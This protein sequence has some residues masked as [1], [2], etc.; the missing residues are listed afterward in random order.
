MRILASVLITGA[1]LLALQAI[2]Q[3]TKEESK[4]EQKMEEVAASTYEHLAT[5][6]IEIERTEDELMKSIL[7]GYH[8]AAKGHLRAAAE[9]KDG[10][11][12]HLE[13]AATEIANIAN[14]GNKRIQA[15]RQRLAK[16]GHTHNTD[17][18]TKE[19]YMF[20]D[21]KEKKEL[22]ALARKVSQL[23]NAAS[24]ND[25]L[26]ALKEFDSLFSRVIASE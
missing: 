7:L 4:S 15:I 20:V 22:V 12:A 10:K 2:G 3:T 8:A 21:S 11:Q 13:A 1:S 14:E 23:G 19:D 16:A 25:V 6:I 9:A 18:V 17:V 26:D 5:A 24:S